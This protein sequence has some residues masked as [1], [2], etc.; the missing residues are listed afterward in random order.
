MVLLTFISPVNGK[1]IV[2]NLEHMNKRVMALFLAFFS[3]LNLNAEVRLQMEKDGGVYKIP[4][5]LNGLKMRFIFDTGASTV[6]MSQNYAIFMAENGYLSKDDIIGHSKSTVADG[7]TIKNKVVNIR[8]LKIGGLELN[9]I[10]AVII[11]SQDAPLLL[12]LSAI[13]KLGPVTIEGQY[14]VIHNINDSGSQSTKSYTEDEIDELYYKG[15]EYYNNE[16]YSFAIDCFKKVYD[17]DGEYVDP[18]VV[19]YIALSYMNIEDYQNAERYGLL[20]IQYVERD[21][22]RIEKHLAYAIMCDAAL[23]VKKYHDFLKYAQYELLYSSSIYEKALATY[24]IADA[25]RYL[26]NYSL[27]NDFYDKSIEFLKTENM[28]D[29][30]KELYLDNLKFKTWCYIALHQF[31]D[32]KKTISLFDKFLKSNSKISSFERLKNEAQ[33]LHRLYDNALYL[34]KAGIDYMEDF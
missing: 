5:E 31:K 15:F 7:R 26:K 4:C 23:S 29:L 22:V 14:L 18:I 34:D 1:V 33:D 24:R 16:L 6:C 2:S 25:Y 3:M 30:E 12:G 32:A 9:N 8:S 17:Y 20:G 21:T 10:E 27:A 13:E 11:D 19:L 28:D